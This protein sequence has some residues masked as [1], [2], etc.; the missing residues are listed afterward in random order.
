M[1]TLRNASAVLLRVVGEDE[2]L[3]A[4]LTLHFTRDANGHA[5][6]LLLNQGR[7]R[8]LRFDRDDKAR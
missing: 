5:T 4:G 8:G 3:G 1:L 6:G 7:A 2:L